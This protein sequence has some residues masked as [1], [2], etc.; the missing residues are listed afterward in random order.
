[1]RI[2]AGAPNQGAVDLGLA[3]KGAGVLRLHT[4]TVQNP[5]GIGEVP[6]NQPRHL[7][8]D[9]QVC[10]GSNRRSSGFSRPN[11]PNGLI[12]NDQRTQPCR[13][14]LMEG[15]A[16]L[17]AQNLLRHTAFPLLLVLTNTNNRYQPMLECSDQ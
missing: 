13:I 12:S 14:D 3:T 16:D 1:M 4:A 9:H 10:L 7:A 2:K 15:Q 11:S 8:A 6:A 5:Q 17:P